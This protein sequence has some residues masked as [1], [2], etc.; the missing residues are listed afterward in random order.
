MS[1]ANHR[2]HASGIAALL[3]IFAAHPV[4]GADAVQST[5]AVSFS[6]DIAP[7]LLRKCVTCHCPEKTKGGYQLQT[8]EALM[9]PGESKETPIVAGE[10][11]R[12][13]LFQL[14]TAKD[15]DDRMPQKDDPLPSVQIALI[16]KWIKEGAKFDG[17]DSKATLA[18]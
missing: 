5:S 18:S 7:L 15:A 8:F 12:S 11:K 14:L 6:K 10:P 3:F 9:K 16:E 2:S 1:S 17:A 4:K 13:R